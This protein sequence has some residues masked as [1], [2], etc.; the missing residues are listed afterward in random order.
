[1]ND[2]LTPAE[3]FALKYHA[4]SLVLSKEMSL[5]DYAAYSKKIYEKLDKTA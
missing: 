5:A 1:M 2:T 4:A 3:Y